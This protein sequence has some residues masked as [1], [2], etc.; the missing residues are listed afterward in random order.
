M[1]I[2]NPYQ[3]LACALL[4][5]ACMVT[6]SAATLKVAEF[7]PNDFSLDASV[8]YDLE[9]QR[10]ID[11]AAT[12]GASLE[13]PAMTIAAR[14]TGW[15][16]H[17]GSILLMRGAT[18]QLS[19]ECAE[20]GAVFHGHDVTDVT[21]I[22][23]TVLGRNDV[24]K[25]GVNIRGVRITGKS[26]RIRIHDM[27]FRDLSSNGVGLFG[28]AD[29]YISDVWVRDV[30]VENCCK[31][32]PD[33]LSGEKVEPNS[34]REDQGD[35]AFYYI[36]DF[37]VDGCRF[38][39]SRSDGTHFYRC[40][41][42][43]ITNNRIYRAKMGGYFIETCE[44][45]IG[46]GNIM[47]ENG[48]RGATIERGC[49]NCVF[50]DNVVRLS[51]REGLWAPDCIG[52]VVTGNLFDRNGRKQNRP[53]RYV[54][55]ANITIDNQ[56]GDPSNSPTRDYL[57]TDNLIY[58]TDSQIAAIRVDATDDTRDIVIRGNLLL[59]ENR[60]VLIQGSNVSEVHCD[61]K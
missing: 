47:W 33:Y 54:W 37:V 49:V 43:Q 24:W 51:G 29:H 11:Q 36:E 61:S 34:V 14:E 50:S 6:V 25:D 55:N 9:I 40:R 46:K 58:T 10:A 12:Q 26:A 3:I 19:A 57:I 18:F 32:Y 17:S 56:R 41:N 60:R 52:L 44:A 16:L 53:P 4:E 27:S 15:R 42:G 39:R 31:R 30:T 5:A 13:F 21:L 22:G 59:G 20:D 38:E 48:S 2:I 45:V 1:K 35:V 28:S 23:G 8:S 7:L